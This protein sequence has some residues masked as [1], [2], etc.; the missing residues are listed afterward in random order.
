MT[1]S[2][3]K[4][5]VTKQID[6]INYSDLSD[7]VEKLLSE[8]EGRKVDIRD[9]AGRDEAQR[10]AFIETQK[11]GDQSWYSTPFDKHSDVQKK[12]H[13]IYNS[14]V[15]HL[16]YMDFWHWWLDNIDNDVSNDT[17]SDID[18]AFAYE[19]NV[20]NLE[21]ELAELED[22]DKAMVEFQ[23]TVLKAFNEVLL[24][25]YTQEELNDYIQIHYSW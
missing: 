14:L 22:D 13:E 10:T 2:R 17:T 9:Y 16:P 25:V 3:H 8:R 11:L 4:E 24:T 18:W 19:V 23:L 7:A 6:Q 21:N 5:V 1:L 20:T 15:E 12:Q